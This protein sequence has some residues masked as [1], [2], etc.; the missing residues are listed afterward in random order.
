MD[1]MVGK[2]GTSASVRLQAARFWGAGEPENAWRYLQP[3]LDAM[4]A[5]SAKPS[6]ETLQ[7][8][9]EVAL[10]LEKDAVARQL[11]ERGRQLY[12]K[13]QRISRDLALVKVRSGETAEARAELDPLVNDLPTDVIDLWSLADL[14]IEA[15][16]KKNAR[17]V[18][19]K[20]PRTT[21]GGLVDF[22][23][24]R[25]LMGDGKWGEA[26]EH[27]ESA[28]TDARFS[29][30]IG[31]RS[32]LLLAQCNEHLLNTDQT[33]KAL[34]RAV[35]I[36]PADGNAMAAGR[37][38]ALAQAAAGEMEPALA[39]L[40]QLVSASRLPSQRRQLNEDIVLLLINRN[41]ALPASKR[42]WSEAIDRLL[43]ERIE[44]LVA[45]CL[46]SAGAAGRRRF[47]HERNGDPA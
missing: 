25:M 21:G 42:N 31:K 10:A 1:E 2:N 39:R 37:Q 15:K 9:G 12:P 5:K 13:N 36:D 23:E 3:D 41:R 47:S 29:Q 46:G 27:L 16:D 43:G 32:N 28:R 14:L 11:F 8:A 22:L 44:T 4:L 35:E 19:G 20:I 33:L 38:L 7:L 40:R 26:A 30:Q 45:R 34:Q 24:A 6:E 17:M 18:K